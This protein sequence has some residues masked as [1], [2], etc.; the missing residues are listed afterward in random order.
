MPGKEQ[1]QRAVRA[2]DQVD[3]A[4]V[5]EPAG[6]RLDIGKESGLRVGQSVVTAVGE[7]FAQLPQSTAGAESSEQ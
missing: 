7:E 6:A 3:G 2:F 1:A 5:G 4:P